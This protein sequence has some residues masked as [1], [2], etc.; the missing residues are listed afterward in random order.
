MCEMQVATSDGPRMGRVDGARRLCEADEEARPHGRGTEAPHPVEA[1][2]GPRGRLREAGRVRELCLWRRPDDR[3]QDS[4]EDAGHRDGVPERPVRGK[5]EVRPDA[6]LLERA[7][8]E[9]EVVLGKERM[10]A[11]GVE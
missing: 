2:R 1:D 3:Q 10:T 4:R 6:A 8:G 7:A 9:A 11:C 5:A